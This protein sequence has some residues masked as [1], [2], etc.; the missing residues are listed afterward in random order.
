MD[1]ASTT[2]QVQGGD[3]ISLRC[4][5]DEVLQIGKQCIDERHGCIPGGS[6]LK[7]SLRGVR[8]SYNSCVAFCA[9]GIPSVYRSRRSP[10]DE[11]ELFRFIRQIQIQHTERYPPLA[12]LHDG[13]VRLPPVDGIV[14]GIHTFH[15]SRRPDRASR[16]T[17]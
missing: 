2:H 17:P 13:A 8:L 12:Q 1:D 10:E 9:S 5:S 14:S 4:I 7:N 11:G 16:R 3:I 6:Q 15:G